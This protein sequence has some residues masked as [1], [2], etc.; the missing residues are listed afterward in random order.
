MTR[1]ER[2]RGRSEVELA[3][4]CLSRRL[5]TREAGATGRS[6]IHALRND[7]SL[8]TP[9]GVV[10]AAVTRGFEL[11][12]QLAILAVHRD[13]PPFTDRDSCDRYYMKEGPR[14]KCRYFPTTLP[15]TCGFLT[16][17]NCR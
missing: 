2:P 9:T 10:R 11:K 5:E 1:V 3:T 8:V 7:S 6:F 13:A 14:A 17:R 16:M 4:P 12:R 15:D